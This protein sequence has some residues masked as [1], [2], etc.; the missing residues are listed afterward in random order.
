M[1]VSEKEKIVEKIIDIMFK[2]NEIFSILQVT[3]LEGEA[4]KIDIVKK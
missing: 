4:I 3:N 1:S 2:L